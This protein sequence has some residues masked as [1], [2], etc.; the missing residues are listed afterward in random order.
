M[1]SQLPGQ[2][3]SACTCEREDHPV[4]PS[5]ARLL[6][7][8]FPDH[9]SLRT[10]PERQRRPRRARDRRHRCVVR[11]LFSSSTS[12]DSLSPS[13]AEQQVDWRKIGSTSQSIQVR[14]Y[15][16]LLVVVEP[17]WLTSRLSHSPA[18]RAY[19][20]RLR[21]EERDALLHDLQRHA[22]RPEPVHRHRVRPALVLARARRVE[23]ELT[24]TFSN[25]PQ[26]PGEREHHL[27]H[28]HDVLRG[29]RLLDLWCAASLRLSRSECAH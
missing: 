1:R 12:A 2:R 22:L 11:L 5:L 19:G 24:L 3:L 6:L 28:R 7:L 21:L 25:R 17:S 14:L 16:A 4:R 23:Q 8:A 26:I 27:A 18:V 9:L 20:R 13:S 10:G 29:P 15:F